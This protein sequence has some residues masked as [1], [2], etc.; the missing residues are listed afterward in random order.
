MEKHQQTVFYSWQSDIASGL[1]RNFIQTALEKAAEAIAS[2]EAIAVEPVI[3][4]D[5]QNVPGAPNIAETILA[6]IDKASVFVADV[7]IIGKARGTR[8]PMPNPNVMVELGYALK[9]LR[10]ERLVLVINTAFGSIDDLPFDLKHRKVLPYSLKQTDFEESA[11]SLEKR[12]QI[13][14]DLQT[15][16]KEALEY[17]FRL[18]PQDT[19]QLPAPLLVLRG[20]ESL[21]NN[22]GA[23][24]GPRGGRISL[25]RFG[26]RRKTVTRD[27]LV[28]TSQLADQ[29][30]HTRL[31]IDQLSGVAE[32][33]RE[34]AGDGAKTAMLLCYEMVRSGY[35]AVSSGA[36]LS[37]VLKGA[38]LAVENTVSYVQEQ[39][40]PLPEEGISNVA[41]TAGGE[42]A[43]KLLVEAFEKSTPDG[44]WTVEE[45]FAPA[46]SSIQAQEGIAFHRG[47]AADDFANDPVS[48]N[49]I[50]DDCFVFVSEGKL[51]SCHQLLPLLSQ[52][53]ESKKP[54]LIL[55]EDIEGE[56]LDTLIMNNNRKIISCVAV[57]APGS[58]DDKQG[59]IR[60]IAVV[61]GANLLGG[62]YGRRLEDADLSNLGRAEK[63]IVEKSQT[64]IV[65]GYGDKDKIKIRLAQLRKQIEQ[66]A[67]Y[68]RAKV[69][70]RL[71]NLIGN[72]AIIKVGGRTQTEL[73]DNK[74]KVSTAMHSVRFA[75]MEGYVLGGG[76]TFYNAAN[77][78]RPQLQSKN[79]GENVGIEIIEKALQEPM[80]WLL[81]TGNEPIETLERR[82]ASLSETGFNLVT[83]KYEDLRYSGVWDSSL[84]M[85]RALE[86][87]FSSAKMILETSSW[88]TIKTEL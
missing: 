49:C 35:D 8:K 79:Q 68:E 29:D 60:D 3:D 37:E 38:E 84:V 63:V 75:L 22:A 11:E 6:K 10:N 54:I 77:W 81:K 36:Q 86:V 7:T 52:V 26:D 44:V 15:K 1:N 41:Q 58:R 27:G 23:T 47:F 43:A 2:S 69:E 17:I 53:A 33:I 55:A 78:L 62:F 67:S 76:L 88:V 51:S 9:G 40:Q 21:R 31:G 73:L 65:G 28:I 70:D 64:R 18:P 45:D 48:G 16:L 14:H 74:Y 24:I 87:A 5:T 19:K 80:R 25:L 30:Y 50:L 34:Q 46:K 39:T 85:Q 56:A 42:L 83:K 13:K 4:R 72:V 32:D 66:T 20:A 71:A 61:T 12:S 57:K 59:W 82:S